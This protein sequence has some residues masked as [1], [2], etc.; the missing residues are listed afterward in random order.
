MLIIVAID[1]FYGCLAA[2]RNDVGGR[3]NGFESVNR[4]SRCFLCDCNHNCCSND[5]PCAVS[6]AT[7]L[8]LYG[9]T[10]YYAM[11]VC[12]IRKRFQQLI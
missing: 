5:D 6:I 11:H 1:S 10:R 8:G 12:S 7:L 4:L 3:R 2:S 9:L